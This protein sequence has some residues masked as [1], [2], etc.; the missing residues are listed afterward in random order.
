VCCSLAKEET[1]GMV[2]LTDKLMVVYCDTMNH[3]PQVELIVF[4]PNVTLLAW[5]SKIISLSIWT[6]KHI[7]SR[8]R[9]P[10]CE[11]F[12]RWQFNGN[13]ELSAT[14]FRHL[15]DK[16]FHFCETETLKKTLGDCGSLLKNQLKSKIL[17]VFIDEAQLFCQSATENCLNRKF[18]FTNTNARQDGL[19]SYLVDYCAFI[20]SGGFRLITGTG[21]TANVSEIIRSIAA[22]KED[23]NHQFLV[24]HPLIEDPKDAIAGI[25]AQMGLPEQFEI[26]LNSPMFRTLL[27]MRRRCF[28]QAASEL[29]YA[30]ILTRPKIRNRLI[31]KQYTR[32]SNAFS[33]LLLT[34]PYKILLMLQMI[35]QLSNLNT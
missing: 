2:G 9:L 12:A 29:C 5:I 1:A 25:L 26:Y 28:T 15:V 22:K 33:Q 11:E 14:I 32:N 30:Y 6:E 20:S 31:A 35:L 34:I 24:G 13:T 27:P 3:L 19:L 8:K 7:D 17:P 21:F 4:G 18:V 10:S 23:T 16:Q